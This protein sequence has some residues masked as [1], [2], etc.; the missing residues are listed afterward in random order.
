MHLPNAARASIVPALLVLGLCPVLRAGEPALIAPEALTAAARRGLALVQKAAANYPNHRTC[1]SCHH[2]TLPMQTMVTA[3]EY[4]LAI[5]EELLQATGRVQPR[6]V[7]RA[8]R[9][10]ARGQGDRRRG[11]DGRLMASG[12]FELAGRAPDEVTEAM[13]VL[14]AQ[15]PAARRAL[16]RPA[17]TGRRSRSRSSPAP[18]SRWRASASTRPAGQREAAAGRDRPGRGLADGCAAHEAAGGSQ[19]PPLGPA[20]ARGRRGSHRRGPRGGPRP[21]STTTAAGR[22]A[23]TCRATPTPPARRSGPLHATGLR[24]DRPG[25]PARASLPARDAARRR[26]LE[27]RDPRQAGPGRT[28]TTA[29]RTASTSSS[30]PPPPAGP[31]PPSRPRCPRQR[32]PPRRAVTTCLIKGGTIVD[33]TGNPWFNGDVAIRGDRIVAVGRVDPDDVAAP[34]HDRRH[35]GWSSPPASSTC[36]RTPTARCSKTATPRAR[37]A[38]A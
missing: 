21:R 27:G 3:R 8:D 13:V 20:P 11:D 24:R 26:L 17:A 1:F 38:R 14:P 15:D 9:A 5:D 32:R 16:G 31:S 35:A 37:S 29:T 19:Q 33:G 18:C 12:R 28:S 22:P 25:L 6:L 10:D 4:G 30:R 2:Q 34:A 36:T 23:T 7:P